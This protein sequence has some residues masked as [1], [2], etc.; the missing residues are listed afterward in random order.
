MGIARET[1]INEML[2]AYPFLLEYLLRQ[3]PRFEKL[4]NP[5]LRRTLGRMANLEKAAQMGGL[6][7]D[8]LVTG[9]NEEIRRHGGQPAVPQQADPASRQAELKAIIRELHAGGDRQALKARFAAFLGEVSP[10]EIAEERTRCRFDLSEPGAGR[11][12]VSLSTPTN[13][14]GRPA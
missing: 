14:A 9:I 11:C 8:Q 7:V 1:K 3:S 6:D 2:E 5:M 10:V 4:K 12:S 13:M